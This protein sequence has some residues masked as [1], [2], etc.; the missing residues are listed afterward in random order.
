M[1]R[2]PWRAV[3]ASKSGGSV[4]FGVLKLASVCPPKVRSAFAK[5]GTETLL[6]LSPEDL[7]SLLRVPVIGAVLRRRQASTENFHVEIIPEL[8]H[9]FLSVLGRNH[10]VAILDQHIV[11]TFANANPL[12][13]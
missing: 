6:L 13:I 10:A 5:N 9:A 3:L 8:D 1:I 4:V 7:S 2:A 11:E 12:N